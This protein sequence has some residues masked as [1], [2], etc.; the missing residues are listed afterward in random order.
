MICWLTINRICNLRCKWCY[1]AAD[2][3]KDIATMSIETVGR[4]QKAI[5][6]DIS[7]FIILGGE[8]T[9]HP[10]LPIIIKK[11]KPTKTVLVTNAVKLAD[12]KYL[13]LLKESGLNVVTI[14][15]KGSTQEQYKENTGVACLDSIEKAIVN[16]NE[17]KIPYSVSVTFSESIMKILPNIVEWMKKTQAE[18]MSINY[19]RPVVLEDKVS[20]DGIPHPKDMAAQTIKSYDLIRKSDVRCVYNFMLPLCLLPFEFIAELA[21]KKLITTICQLQK[22]NG[23]IFLPDGSLIPCNHL[24]DY[25]LG[26]IGEDFSTKLEFEKFKKRKNVQDFYQKTRNLPDKRCQDCSMKIQCGGGCF[27]QYLYYKPADIIYGP[28]KN[29]VR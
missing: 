10:D 11:L 5:L 4:I 2:G 13:R 17:S 21:E 22:D 9:L 18:T 15:L 26:K 25:K 28:F 20:I 23:L 7:R 1:A 14:S 24:F 19:C 8:P 6:P 27:I 29:S 16:L 12:K 3:F